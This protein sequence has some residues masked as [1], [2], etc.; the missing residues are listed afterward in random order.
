MARTMSDRPTTETGRWLAETWPPRTATPSLVA[1]I[2]REARTNETEPH[3]TPEREAGLDRQRLADTFVLM[4]TPAASA[5]LD[6]F[7]AFYEDYDDD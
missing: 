4:G 3:E 7:I 5:Y 2:E 6:D 1:A